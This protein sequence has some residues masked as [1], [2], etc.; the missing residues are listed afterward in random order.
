AGIASGEAHLEFLRPLARGTECAC[1]RSDAP[2]VHRNPCPTC[3]APMVSLRGWTS[4]LPLGELPPDL[5]AA[6]L[7]LPEHDL[8]LLRG[9]K[10]LSSTAQD[11]LT[12]AVEGGVHK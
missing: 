7:G 5:T 6:S 12:I 1:G 8:L 3:Q 11:A 2:R 4:E 10:P 9:P